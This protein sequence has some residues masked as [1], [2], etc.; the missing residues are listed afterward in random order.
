MLPYSLVISQTSS[1][2]FGIHN[3]VFGMADINATNTRPYLSRWS[4]CVD[5]QLSGNKDWHCRSIRI[6]V[7]RAAKYGSPLVV[8]R[9]L[10]ACCSLFPSSHSY[11]FSLGCTCTTSER[12][13]Q[14]H[15]T[16]CSKLYFSSLSQFLCPFRL[17]LPLLLALPLSPSHP[18]SLLCCPTEAWG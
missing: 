8:Q 16:R 18:P 10:P 14:F 2:Q 3:E 6:W 12:S 1:L 15:G 13:M 5:L 9:L 17:P 4:A 11:S 7:G